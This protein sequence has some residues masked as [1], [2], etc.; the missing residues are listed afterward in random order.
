MRCFV[1]MLLL[2][3]FFIPY[4]RCVSINEIMYNPPG[5][6]NN[7][8]FIELY[9]T[10][11]LSAYTVGDLG[12]NDTLALLKFIP[13]NFSLV[14]EE[15]FNHTEINCSVYSAGATIGNNLNNDADTI[16]LYHEGVLVDSASYDGSLAN[17][18]GYSL[19]MVNFSWRES[20]EIGGSP[21]SNNCQQIILYNQSL[22]ETV[23]NTVNE[24]INTT[25]N[26]TGQNSTL[27][28]PT[29]NNTL[30]NATNNTGNNTGNI[31]GNNTQ[32]NANA[33]SGRC[34]VQLSLGTDKQL[35]ENGE[36]VKIINSINNKSF[37]F[38]I[39]YWVEDLFGNL[40]KAKQ[41]TTNTNPK[42]FT[43]SIKEKDKVF[44][45]K[46]NLAMVG[47]DNSNEELEN[48]K[49]IIFKNPDVEEEAEEAEPEE[50]S[51]SKSGLAVESAEIISFY[52]RSKKY[53]EKINLYAN[54][55]ATKGYDVVLAS[56][57][58]EQ[59]IG[60]NGTSSMKF[61]VEPE[62]G[63]NLYV[64]QLRKGSEVID[65]KSLLFELEADDALKKQDTPGA[66]R[67]ITVQNTTKKILNN[68]ANNTASKVSVA[69]NS[70][71]K[72]SSQSSDQI[73]GSVV[74]E[75]PNARAVKYV[76]YVIVGLA[77]LAGAGFFISKRER[78]Q[79][80]NKKE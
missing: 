67:T 65:I 73:T 44:I 24:T 77:L 35:Y 13:G 68:T 26:E 32:S 14:V 31:T 5:D 51:T 62:P 46:N 42:S 4:A 66:N 59:S 76:P 57:N 78:V 56:S 71:S 69:K 40:A 25:M 52:T 39:E 72:S 17:N 61:E 11:N 38:T 30:S 18:N 23:N 75:S 16:F 27:P 49:I 3:L 10:D 41:S 8:E 60:F 54:V 34:F 29:D 79:K 47:C 37:S 36:S 22:N 19:E 55:K 20:C 9:G 45:V 48:E 12:S 80:E 1:I 63:I 50:K 74:Y 28:Q 7:Q 43:P 33:T 58:G 21:G 70:S 64:L 2:P 6:D 53:S 15:G